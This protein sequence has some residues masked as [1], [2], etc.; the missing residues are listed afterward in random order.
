M[1]SI[2]GVHDT[3]VMVLIES[4]LSK[5]YIEQMDI[6]GRDVVKAFKEN[7]EEDLFKFEFPRNYSEDI[8]ITHEDGSKTLIEKEFFYYEPM[9]HITNFL[10]QLLIMNLE[11]ETKLREELMRLEITQHKL[12]KID[13]N[14]K[15]NNYSLDELKLKIH[16]IQKSYR[17]LL[18]IAKPL[19]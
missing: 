14:M 13:R 7:K 1:F 5:E 17:E 2:I 16:S 4:G 6:P 18:E 11:R 10:N 3:L 8:Y 9:Q 12:E 19:L 15:I